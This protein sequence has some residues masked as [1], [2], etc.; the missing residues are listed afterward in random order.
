M[1]TYFFTDCI[2]DDLKRFNSLFKKEVRSKNSL[3]SLI[4][5]YILKTKG[6]QLRPTLVF[7]TAKMCG[8]ITEETYSGACMVE[9]MHTATL[10]HDDVV[11]DAIKRR[12]FFSIN[13]L[14]K[15]KASVLMGDYFLAK[16]L[17]YAL[18]RN[19]I[20]LLHIIS[21]AVKEMSEGEIMQIEKNRSFSNNE[22]TYYE[23]IEKKTASLFVAAMNAGAESTAGAS[24]QTKKKVREMAHLMGLAFQIKDDLLDYSKT[25]LTGKQTWN[26]L[27]EQKMTLPIIYALSQAP[28]KEQKY[29]VKRFYSKKNT[30]ADYKEI[31]SFISQ[32]KGFEY[33]ERK[34]EELCSQ[35]QQIVETFEKSEARDAFLNLISYI[36]AREK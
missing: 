1:S 25:S 18:E 33:A 32:Y 14:W 4:T 2:S 8:G 26:D 34:V 5:S 3:F 7:L 27:K 24:E 36:S 21:I 20:S 30:T 31:S 19:H 23:I 22:E 9:L 12:G 29:I 15:N 11:D 6:K 16:G 28:Q 17:L 13:A 10:I 35:A